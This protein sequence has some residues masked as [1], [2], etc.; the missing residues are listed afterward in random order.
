MKEIKGVVWE[1]GTERK[2]QWKVRR[3]FKKDDGQQGSDASGI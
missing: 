3:G 2:E 1:T